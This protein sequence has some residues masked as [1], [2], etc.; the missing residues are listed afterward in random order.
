MGFSGKCLRCLRTFSRILH[1]MAGAKTGK[2]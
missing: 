1:F 2:Y